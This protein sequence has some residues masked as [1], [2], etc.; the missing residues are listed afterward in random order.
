MFDNFN[1]AFREEQN[2]KAFCQQTLWS[3]RMPNRTAQRTLSGSGQSHLSAYD[4]D[5]R[6]WQLDPPACRRHRPFLVSRSPALVP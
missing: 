2:T 4:N 6:S 5:F 3:P 1:D